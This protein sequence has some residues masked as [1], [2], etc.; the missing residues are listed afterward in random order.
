M[1][2]TSDNLRRY[3]RDATFIEDAFASGEYSLAQLADI[4]K[5][6]WWVEEPEH[7]ADLRDVLVA[8]VNNHKRRVVDFLVHGE[9]N[10][11][12]EYDHTFTAGGVAA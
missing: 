11:L 12:P 10:T 4:A 9:G 8:R 5:G 3:A 1:I 7:Y 2:E 6:P